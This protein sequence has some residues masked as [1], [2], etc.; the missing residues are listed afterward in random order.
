VTWN[1]IHHKTR[2]DRHEYGYPDANYLASVTAELAQHGI[3]E[4]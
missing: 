3:R 4:D 1:D 2:T